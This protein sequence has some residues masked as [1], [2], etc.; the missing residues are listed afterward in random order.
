MHGEVHNHFHFPAD[1]RMEEVIQTLRRI[2][3]RE[4]R[5]M[6]KLRDDMNARFAT[7]IEEVRQTR[8][9]ADAN[10]A[11]SRRMLE[12]LRGLRDELADKLE[13]ADI[14]RMDAMTG[15]LD[16][17]QQVLA[18]ASAEGID[19]P[20]PQPGPGPGPGPDPAPQARPAQ[21]PEVPPG[22]VPEQG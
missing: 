19:D 6:A 21:K 2:D 20:E 17:S 11:F 5:E 16:D 13:A 4:V 15:G 14:E 12:E 9:A 22:P 7:M 18:E 8:T 10:L 1:P 3:R